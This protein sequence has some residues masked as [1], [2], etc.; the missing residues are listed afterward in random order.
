M[1]SILPF[2]WFFLLC[3]MIVL[4]VIL[5]G[6]DLGLGIMSL[7]EPENRRSRIIE[8]VGPCGMPTRLGWSLQGLLYSEPFLRFI[9]SF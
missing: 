9:A 2:L 6:A 3:G 1:E 4:F 7:L 5:D 8:A